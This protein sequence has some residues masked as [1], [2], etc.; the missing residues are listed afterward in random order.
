MKLKN[1]G[2]KVISVGETVI[3]PGEAKEVKGY[4]ENNAALNCLIKKKELTVIKEKA[5]GRGK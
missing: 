5:T 1:T 4:D 3:L 2:H